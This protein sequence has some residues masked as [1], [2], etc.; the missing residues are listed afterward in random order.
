MEKFDELVRKQFEAPDGSELDHFLK[1]CLVFRDITEFI[2]ITSIEDKDN[3]EKN[4]TSSLKMLKIFVIMAAKAFSEQALLVMQK[5]FTCIACATAFLK[6]Q[7]ESVMIVVLDWVC[8][9]CKVLSIA[10]RKAK[11]S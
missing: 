2:N 9:Q 5:V 4:W 10:T 1:G 6:L 3:C 8:S 7:G 11:M